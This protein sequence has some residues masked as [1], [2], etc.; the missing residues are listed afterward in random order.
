VLT[1]HLH[2]SHTNGATSFTFDVRENDKTYRV[3]IVNMASINPGFRLT[4]MPGFPAVEQAY[5][6]TF[7]DACNPYRSVDPQQFQTGV[8]RLGFFMRKRFH[9]HSN[10]EAAHRILIRRRIQDPDRIVRE[11]AKDAP[12]CTLEGD[13]VF[14]AGFVGD[15]FVGIQ[16]ACVSLVSTWAGAAGSTGELCASGP[17]ASHLAI[18]CIG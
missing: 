2:P 3:G 18:A 6:R 13:H 1:A 5:E 7:H 17:R 15:D 12:P 9:L 4:G 8:A 10:I 11:R 14:R 16:G